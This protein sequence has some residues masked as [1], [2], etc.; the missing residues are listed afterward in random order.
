VCL[1]GSI[2]GHFSTFAAEW[3]FLM[4]TQTLDPERAGRGARTQSLFRDVNEGV[5]AINESFSLVVP[6]GDWICECSNQGCSDHIGLTL[7]EYEAIR[8]DATRFCVSPDGSHVDL[9][10]EDVVNE[11]DRFWVVEKKGLAAELAR[12]VDPRAS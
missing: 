5:K 11:T 8:S 4:D 10:I 9:A 7:P 1:R 3:G 2:P 12:S 6:L